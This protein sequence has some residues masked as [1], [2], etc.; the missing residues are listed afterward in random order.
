MARTRRPKQTK[1]EGKFNDALAAKAIELAR[2]GAYRQT[3][4]KLCGIDRSTLYDWLSRDDQPYADFATK[5]VEA[6]AEC[7]HE[8]AQAIRDSPDPIDRKWFLSRR[9]PERW[10][11]RKQ[12]TM[13]G[14][15][16]VGA[17]IDASAFADDRAREHIFGLLDYLNAETGEDDAGTQPTGESGD[18]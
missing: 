14:S 4:A 8:L 18:Q 9:Y 10:G 15:I 17:K 13:G 3:V 2:Q 5:F 16:D 7:E 6:E 1:T 11:E 12:V